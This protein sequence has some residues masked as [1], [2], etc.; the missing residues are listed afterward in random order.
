MPGSPPAPAEPDAARGLAL[1]WLIVLVAAVLPALWIALARPSAPSD[2]TFTDP[3][4]RTWS[5]NGATLA[6]VAPGFSDLRAGDRVVGVDGVPIA[7]RLADHHPIPSPRPGDHL[8]YQVIRAGAGPVID[9]PVRVGRYPLGQLAAAHADAIPLLA[10]LFAVSAYVF[11]RRPR[12]PAAR[13]LFAIAALVPWGAT[14]WPLGTGVLDLVCGPRLW[15][16]VVGDLAN[17][18]VWAMV[19]RFALVF[20]R[21]HG[22]AARWPRSL[23]AVYALPFLL[24]GATLA[25]ALPRSDD[26]LVRLTWLVRLSVPAAHV[27]PI[28]IGIFFVAGYRS[29]DDPA[30][31]PRM[32][33]VLATFFLG[34]TAYLGLG[35]LPDRLL[36]HPLVAWNW[37][38][39]FF[40]PF[41]LALG[42]AVLRHQLFNIDVILTRSLVYGSLGVIAVGG[43]LG[44][45]ALLGLAFDARP[46]VIPLLAV[47]IAALGAQALRFR[48]Q[49]MI[50]RM[51]YGARDDPPAVIASLGSRLES[52]PDGENALA[53]VVETLAQVLRLSYAAIE[54]AG[55]DADPARDPDGRPGRPGGWGRVEVGRPTRAPIVVPLAHGGQAIG[56]LL[57][58]TGPSRE[59]FGAADRRL[60]NALARQVEV[61]AHNVLLGA[62]LAHSLE[63]SVLGREEERRRIR[64]DIHDGLG[65]TLAAVA[66]KLDVARSRVRTDPAGAEKLLDDLAETHH[67]M[68]GD[69]RRLV[70]GLRPPALDRLGLVAALELHA[71]GL[72]RHPLE[73]AVCSLGPLGPLPAATEIAAYRICLE[74]MTNVIRHA[75]ARRC[76]VRL[77]ETP[78][79]LLVE[80]LDDG[81][82]LPAHHRVGV[83]LQSVRDRAAELGGDCAVS[84]RPEG[85]GTIVRAW[86]PLADVPAVPADPAARAS[87]ASTSNNELTPAVQSLP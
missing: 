31:R 44:A 60:L 41:P 13:A 28:L 27:F 40:L 70:D 55:P 21:P 20:P 75:G 19:G 47:A 25:V 2:G 69:L 82:G 4:A 80:V 67:E 50:G 86:L 77:E 85:G 45:V 81:M 63:R 14:A 87:P 73:I 76:Q 35:Q 62:R 11:L 38:P 12:D 52:R 71:R 72:T 1:P 83:G 10:L 66:M 65:P 26:P 34:A 49:R 43:Y 79:R 78:D 18:L 8:T 61:T 57:L 37:Q 3:Q 51:M 64:R 22:F 7:R 17:C 30:D 36:G 23:A 53:T 54:L 29:A 59:P 5:A 48:L 39:V 42:A 58:D 74:A 24:Y 16:F 6:E 9:V 33:W 68:V 56:R 46:G 84:S 32:R 15:P